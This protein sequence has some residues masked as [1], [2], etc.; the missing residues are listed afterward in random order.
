LCLI[1]ICWL[2]GV[3]FGTCDGSNDIG[4]LVLKKFSGC[5]S[6]DAGIKSWGR[7]IPVA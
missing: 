5:F 1:T 2:F 4:I 3:W 6:P 7:G